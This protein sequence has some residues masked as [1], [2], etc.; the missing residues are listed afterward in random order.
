[1]ITGIY[2][3]PVYKEFAG[4]STDDKPTGELVLENSLFLE[5]DTGDFYYYTKGGGALYDGSITCTLDDEEY[6]YAFNFVLEADSIVVVYD[7]ETYN[8]SNS[9]VE[10]GVYV[11]GD[12]EL[13]TTPFLIETYEG[14]TTF[15][16]S[17]GNEH[18][19]KI[20]TGA[21]GGWAKVGGE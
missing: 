1:M 11:Y 4:L 2:G 10:E 17:D 8:L 16:T 7:N 15:Y 13:S 5:L 19:L 21:A 6:S 12:S 14:V 20:S 3:Q 18:T 9:A